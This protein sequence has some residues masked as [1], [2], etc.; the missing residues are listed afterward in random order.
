MVKARKLRCSE[1]YEVSSFFEKIEGST[2]KILTAF[3]LLVLAPSYLH[4]ETQK[5]SSQDAPRTWYYCAKERSYYPYVK[6]CSGGWLQVEAAERAEA[7][8]VDKRVLDYKA[9]IIAKI[10]RNIVTLP[11]IPYNARAV[12]D[13]TLL[14]GGMVSQ[15]ITVKPS[16]SVAYDAAVESAIIKAQPLPVPSEISLFNNFRELRLTFSPQESNPSSEKERIGKARTMTASDFCKKL[17]ESSE[18]KEFATLAK[19]LATKHDSGYVFETEDKLVSTWI[20]GKLKPMLQVKQIISSKDPLYDYIHPSE[21]A[22]NECA[23]SIR[24]TDLLYLMAKD[25]RDYEALK[26]E[27][28]KVAETQAPQTVRKFDASG[29]IVNETTVQ[30][31]EQRIRAI[32]HYSGGTSVQRVLGGD[33]V[34]I[35]PQ[36]LVTWLVLLDEKGEILKNV[37]PEIKSQTV[38]L[39]EK[40]EKLDNKKKASAESEEKMSKEA[41]DRKAKMDSAQQAEI[42]KYRAF[43]NSPE[44]K[45]ILAYQF[46]QVVQTCNEVRKGYAAQF[47][48][49]EEFAASTRKIKFVESTV[50]P[51][52]QDK[53]TDKLWARALTR[54]QKWHPTEDLGFDTGLTDVIDRIQSNNK[55][56]FVAAQADCAHF[57]GRFNNFSEGII[58]KEVPKKSF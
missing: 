4:A 41:A 51:A 32:G 37:Y 36:W 53:N 26:S 58:G 57:F 10:R 40:L 25:Q 35:A 14:P 7:S 12:F 39:L 24:N 8:I 45:L 6:Q 34:S 56:N 1:L 52:L 15:V 29:N 49:D 55:S 54:N 43:A 5:Y 33:D 48:N 31:K 38:A 46:Y 2:M 13:I 50:K 27:L 11:D 16:G 20:S 47:V 22:A 23:L 3:I 17:E 44:G 19:T 18:L 30:A 9:S 28:D 42:N 21:D